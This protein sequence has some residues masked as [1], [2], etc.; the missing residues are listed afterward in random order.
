VGGVPPR[1]QT[2]RPLPCGRLAGSVRGGWPWTRRPWSTAAVCLP[3][4]PRRVAST[5]AA[6]P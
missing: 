1:E 5:V 4:Q 6:W 3:A 2:R